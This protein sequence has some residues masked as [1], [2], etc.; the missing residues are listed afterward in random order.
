MKSFGI[1]GGGGS[2]FA[3]GGGGYEKFRILGGLL[4]FLDFLD[5]CIFSYIFPIKNFWNFDWGGGL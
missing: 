1:I 3:G 2:F 4:Q 5:F